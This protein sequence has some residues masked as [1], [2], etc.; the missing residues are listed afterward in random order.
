M[1]NSKLGDLSANAVDRVRQLAGTFIEGVQSRLGIKIGPD[2]AL[3]TWAARHASW[4]LNR[5]Q[6]VKGATPYELVYGKSYKGLLAEYAEP[7]HGYTKSLNKGARW[8]L[9]L[10]LGKVERQDAYVLY[11]WSAGSAQQMHQKN[12]SRLVQILTHTQKLQCVFRGRIKPT[13]EAGLF[14]KESRQM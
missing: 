1:V 7:V 10:F 13:L 12:R 2:H 8:R 5:F 4:A 11:R 6:P 14:F 9:C 3:W